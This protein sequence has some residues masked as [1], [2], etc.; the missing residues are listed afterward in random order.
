MEIYL[1]I[2]YYSSLLFF[3]IYKH[4][5]DLR[6]ENAVWICL[7]NIN[8]TINNTALINL[9]ETWGT[10]KI[11]YNIVLP[12]IVFLHK[13]F[14][15]FGIQLS[16]TNTQLFNYLKNGFYEAISPGHSWRCGL[17]IFL[18]TTVFLHWLL[19]WCVWSLGYIHQGCAK[20][21]GSSI[22]LWVW[23][24]VASPVKIFLVIVGVI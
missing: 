12:L 5:L 14:L 22:I 9:W 4:S 18:Q 19:A 3:P 7:N 20:N 6:Y 24:G 23:K 1:C 10:L 21:R 15:S 8:S 11:W 13:Y 16:Q 17:I 2:R